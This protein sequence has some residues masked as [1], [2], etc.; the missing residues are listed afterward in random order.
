MAAHQDDIP[1]TS[2]RPS[3]SRSRT[4]DADSTTSGVIRPGIGPY[5]CQ[6]C[7]RSVSSRSAP[8][9]PA[10]RR[11]SPAP[12]LS[13]GPHPDRHLNGGALE[14]ELLAQLAFHEPPVRSLKKARC[15]QNK[16]RR[17]RSEE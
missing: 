10:T 15:E 3:A 13:F 5:G 8:R 7:L 4:P 2:S 17:L 12:V 6:T 1:S 14:A 11:A 16:G 9:G